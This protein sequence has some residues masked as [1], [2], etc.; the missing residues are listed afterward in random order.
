MQISNVNEVKK[1]NDKYKQLTN[2]E[3]ERFRRTINYLLNK[4]FVL[5]EIHDTQDRIGKFN[6]DYRFIE[7]YSELF[8]DF[9]ELAGYTLNKDENLGIYEISSIYEYNLIRLDKFT[10]LM[11]ITL[12][13]IYDSELEKNPARKAIL[14]NTATVILQMMENNLVMKKPTI[15]ECAASLRNLMRYNVITKFSGDV[16]Q[17]EFN[18]LIYPTILKVVS[19]E[20]LTA[21]YNLM[22][23][24]ED[25][26]EN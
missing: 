17:S 2:A 7:R 6:P 1:M 11:L 13:Q 8:D 5:R 15:R 18:F 4:S 20:K 23:K 24:N 9:L 3:K 10:T 12:R 22:L 16:D 21:I 19:N 25:E 26:S 14:S